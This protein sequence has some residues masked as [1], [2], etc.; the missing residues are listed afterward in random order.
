MLPEIILGAVVNSRSPLI[1]TLYADPYSAEPRTS[2][3]GAGSD[4]TN[5]GG[6][7]LSE[8][9]AAFAVLAAWPG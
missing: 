7:P 1:Y 6:R 2:I 9:K 4:Q 8:E 3:H 5:D